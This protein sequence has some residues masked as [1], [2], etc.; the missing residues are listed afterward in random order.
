[1]NFQKQFALFVAIFLYSAHA[2]ATVIRYT[3][4]QTTLAGG[5]TVTGF[6]DWDTTLPDL[7][8]N[9]EGSVSNYDFFITGGNTSLFVPVTM[10]DEIFGPVNQGGI[11]GTRSG[12]TFGNVFSDDFQLSVWLDTAIYNFGQDLVISSIVHPGFS[13]QA[14]D[15][16]GDDTLEQRGVETGQ[17]IGTVIPEPTS[18]ALLGLG[19]LLVGRR[20]RS[21]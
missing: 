9:Y 8:P 3:F 14:V 18:L 1:M 13:G 11:A 5:G 12:I 19:G 7:Q 10:T 21:Y 4:D 15:P 2:D 16:P 20:R 17:L 6:F